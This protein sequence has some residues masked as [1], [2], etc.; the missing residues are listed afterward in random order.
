MHTLR[1]FQL[2]PVICTVHPV[3]LD[4]S[5]CPK[6][7]PVFAAHCAS[8]RLRRQLAAEGGPFGIR[9]NSITPGLV[10]TEAMANIPKEMATGLIAAQTTQQAVD[11]IDIA[12]AYLFLSSDEARQI[13]AANLPVDGGTANAATGGM[14]GKEPALV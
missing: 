3:G 8:Q 12:Y 6:Q 5:A 10:W 1:A 4:L 7:I 9:C 2:R 11:P 14:Q 13:T